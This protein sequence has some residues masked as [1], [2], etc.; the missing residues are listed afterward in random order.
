MDV[1]P[2]RAQVHDWIADNLPGAV[3]GHVTAA[4]GLENLNTARHKLLGRGKNVRAAVFLDADGDDVRMLQQ[5]QGVGNAIGLAILDEGALQLEAVRVRNEPESS[6][7]EG[8]HSPERAELVLARGARRVDGHHTW[9]G[10]KFSR[11]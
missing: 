6:H 1:A 7:V 5:E 11:P 8:A 3:I 9:E 2:I 10:S 4:A